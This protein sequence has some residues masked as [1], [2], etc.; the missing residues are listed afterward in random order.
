M[1]QCRRHPART[2]MCPAALVKLPPGA[3]TRT[4]IDTFQGRYKLSPLDLRENWPSLLRHM[5]LSGNSVFNP[6]SY[7]SNTFAS[8]QDFWIEND[9]W[10]YLMTR[11]AILENQS[12]YGNVPAATG[13]DPYNDLYLAFNQAYSFY[14]QGMDF[15]CTQ[16]IA[17]CLDVIARI[18][19]RL[20]GGG[21]FGYGKGIYMEVIEMGRL[22]APIVAEI[23]SALGTAGMYGLLGSI[24]KMTGGDD[25]TL[26][27]MLMAITLSQQSYV[28]AIAWVEYNNTGSYLAEDIV[29][30]L[31]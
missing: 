30:I 21:V 13:L 26:R 6:V 19:E 25:Q 11:C 27:R 1:P 18:C 31:W 23:D 14:K 5:R 7:F 15:E 9:T 12:R 16:V 2:C 3:T 10:N 22:F 17:G 24:Y 4:L 8:P 29:N 28:L 20:S